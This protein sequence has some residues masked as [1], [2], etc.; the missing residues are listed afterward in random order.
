MKPS[1]STLKKTFDLTPLSFVIVLFH[2][3]YN[4]LCSP[5]KS[6]LKGKKCKSSF[7]QDSLQGSKWET[8]PTILLYFPYKFL[9]SLHKK[10]YGVW[11]GWAH[12]LFLRGRIAVIITVLRSRSKQ[13][14]SRSPIA[15][16]WGKQSVASSKQG[17][18]NWK[19]P[20]AVDLCYTYSMV[21]Y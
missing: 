3:S 15:N 5:L 4:I 7:P 16:R 8:I 11:Q 17:Q 19:A 1:I 2:R 10:E 20:D 13:E 12:Y 6:L 9:F 21:N 18:Q 14:R